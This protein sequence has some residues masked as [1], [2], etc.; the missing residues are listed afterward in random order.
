MLTAGSASLGLAGAGLVLTIVS[1]DAAKKAV[2][3]VGPW[4]PALSE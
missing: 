4:D 2:A 3:E 1:G